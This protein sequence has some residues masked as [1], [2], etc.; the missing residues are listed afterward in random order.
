MEE[1]GSATVAL[2]HSLTGGRTRTDVIIYSER[3]TAGW[4]V[5][6]FEGSLFSRLKE[7]VDD[8]KMP[9][10]RSRSRLVYL[11]IYTTGF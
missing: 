4:L 6:Y 11:F 8:K 7:K 1:V 5:A 9:L 10:D 2:P 3:D